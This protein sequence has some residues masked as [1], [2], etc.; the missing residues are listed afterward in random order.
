[1][2]CAWKELLSILPSGLQ[3]AVQQQASNCLQEIRLRLNR[4]PVLVLQHKQ[5]TLDRRTSREDLS[6]IIHTASRYSPWIASSQSSGYITAPGGHRIGICG[7]AVVNA[8]KMEG[9]RYLRSLNIRVARDFPGISGPLSNEAGSILIL[10]PPGAGKT[11]FL[12]DLIRQR[13]RNENVAVVDERGEL[14]P[15]NDCFD[16]GF[17]TDIL[18]GCPKPQGIERLLRTMGPDTIAVDEITAAADCEALLQAGWCGVQV[19]ATVHAASVS[20]LQQRPLYAPL[21]R[22]GLFK[23]LVVLQRDKSW[24][25]ERIRL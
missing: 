9:F 15:I 12:R 5:I 18:T 11:T 10:G 21:L 14:F 2:K 7:E 1:M 20:D 19:L 6:F 4:P 25:L 8:G 17:G 13:S 22:T 16:M 23:A 3:A 24:K